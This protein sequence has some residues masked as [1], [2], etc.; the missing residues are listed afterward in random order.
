MLCG[1]FL[2]RNTAEMAKT[3]GV[4]RGVGVADHSSEGG[5]LR[6]VLSV[7]KVRA[8]PCGVQLLRGEQ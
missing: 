6:A 4:L 3:Y 7:M 5:V 8:G 2:Q 1:L